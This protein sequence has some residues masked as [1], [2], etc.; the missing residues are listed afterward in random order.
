M[1]DTRATI[2]FQD[3][4]ELASSEKVCLLLLTLFD[5][6]EECTALQ[7]LVTRLFVKVVHVLHTSS[8]EVGGASGNGVWH[9]V[10][11]I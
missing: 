8:T 2:C 11:V 1:N 7:V 3:N 6:R 5:P 9:E 4:R 10:K